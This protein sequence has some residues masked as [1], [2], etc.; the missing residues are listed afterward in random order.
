[1]KY[2][3]LRKVEKRGWVCFIEVMRKANAVI[4]PLWLFTQNLIALD[5]YNLG[6]LPGQTNSIGACIS[7]DG[8]VACAVSGSPLTTPFRWTT[9]G[10]AQS[11]GYL[12]G[13]TFSYPTGVNSNGSV[14]VGWGNINASQN[15]AFRWTQANGMQSL[16]L[17]LGGTNSYASGVNSDG[18][19]IVGIGDTT[20]GTRAFR[21]TQAGGLQDLGSLGTNSYATAVSANGSI[22]VGN[23]DQKAFKWTQ[24]SGMQ[25]LGALPGNTSSSAR[26]ISADGSVI[27]GYSQLST[28]STPVRWTLSGGIQSLGR[29]DTSHNQAHAS[30]VSADGSII[31][32]SSGSSGFNAFLWTETEGIKDLKTHLESLGLDLTMWRLTDAIGISDDGDTIIGA[33]YYFGETPFGQQRAFVVSGFRFFLKTGV[34]NTNFGVI[35]AGGTKS[36]NSIVS[37]EATP[38]PGYVFTGWSGDI[39]GSINPVNVTMTASKK[40]IA[41]FSQDLSDDDQDGLS[42]YAEIVLHGSSP[43]LADSNQDGINDLQATVLGYSPNINFTSLFNFMKTNNASANAVGLFSTNQIMDLKFGGMILGKT[44][45]QLSLTYE[46]LQSSNLVS[47]TT[48]RQETVTISNPPASKMFLRINPKQ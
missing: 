18:T 40:V 33:G 23:S 36:Q 7:P 26:D 13:G 35:T 9:Q 15:R 1:V 4:F 39:S 24:S 8:Q 25:N 11:L 42:N 43:N 12:S 32:G 45:N 22:V 29:L 19:V 2:P 20:S 3:T 44:N 10:G 27:V 6:T 28:T 34:N 30:A 38:N 31:V 41:Q 48:N 5:F 16:G 21:W 47:W 14:I 17:L 37:V 46:I